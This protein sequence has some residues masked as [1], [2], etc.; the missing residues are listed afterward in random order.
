M[1]RKL[2]LEE[3]SD[4][5]LYRSQDLVKAGCGDCHG[6]W[7]CCTG[8]GN[9]I[10]LDP[11]DVFR[12]E[13]GLGQSFPE[14][15]SSALDLNVVDGIVLPNLRMA[16]SQERCV[17]L[18]SEGRCRIHAFR[19]GFCRLFPLG[20]IYEGD[21]FRYFLQVHECP[22]QPKTKVK[23][24]KW[25]DTPNLKTYEDFVLSWHQFLKKAEAL[26]EQ[27]SR[28]ETAENRSDTG[29]SLP[30]TTRQLSLY[31]LQTFYLA[32]YDLSGDFY[33]Q[34]AA[35]QAAGEAFLAQV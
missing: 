18:N 29:T 26:L 7:Q 5:R 35:R 1:R 13:Q 22:R 30:D 17:F 11:L 23:I 24:S 21:G 27:P 8:M 16:G 28:P 3:V 12:L 20:R 4:G 2:N 6:C 33:A 25:L 19:P 9:S 32:P 15:L 10:L 34:Y 31:I 14:L